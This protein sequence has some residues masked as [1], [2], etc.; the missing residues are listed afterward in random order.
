MKS[1]NNK[2]LIIFILAII[3]GAIQVYLFSESFNFI[4][5]IFQGLGFLVISLCITLIWSIF[6]LK[7][8]GFLKVFY[9]SCILSFVLYILSLSFSK[10]NDIPLTTREISNQEDKYKKIVNTENKKPIKKVGDVKREFLNEDNF[11]ENYVYNYAIKFPE[12]YQLNYGI[13]EYSNILAYNES[14]GKQISISTGNNNVDYSFSNEK[15]NEMI[16][17]YKKKHL[18][19]F[20]NGIIKKWKK[21]G[22]YQDVKVV[23]EEVVNFYNKKFI[24]LTFEGTRNLNNTDYL[25]TIIDFITFFNDYNY[26]FYFESPKPQNKTDWAQWDNLIFDTM[27]R[28]RISNTITQ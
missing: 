12:N 26:H 23:S 10:F 6:R 8:W 16:D 3:F 1:N 22:S 7:R 9:K 4:T 27:S 11:Y 13:G 24:K 2:Q 5:L 20:T 14:N 18:D 21:E 19:F 28:V 15:A 25:Y 17:S